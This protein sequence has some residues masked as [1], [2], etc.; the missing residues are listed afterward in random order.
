MVKVFLIFILS[1]FLCD[2]VTQTNYI[3][4]RKNEYKDLKTKRLFFKKYNI[5]ILEHVLHHIFF[6]LIL[7]IIFKEFDLRLVVAT[8]IIAILHYIIDEVKIHFTEDSIKKN[9]SLLE[10]QKNTF[11]YLLEKSTFYFLLDQ[12]LHIGTI[13][14]VLLTLGKTEYPGE[15]IQSTKDFIFIDTPVN[16]DIKIIS[17]GISLILLTFGSG[18]LI[19][20][21]FKDINKGQL[22]TDETAVSIETI[23]KDK[24]T[25]ISSNINNIEKNLVIERS[26]EFEE[27]ENENKSKQSIKIQYPNFNEKDNNAVGKYIGILERFLIA[28]FIIIGA[29]PGLVLLGAFKTL[30]RF[31]QFEDKSFAEKYLIGTLLSIVLGIIMGGIIKRIL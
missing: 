14:L 15:I 22:L 5:G 29:Y 1:H 17:L 12:L 16:D 18:Y 7:L 8:L 11:N 20:E 31:R 26:W 19:A 6:T 25:N 9:R 4:K 30:T 21:I 2:F 27:T 3:I 10:E 13:Y 23:E 28:V 24:L